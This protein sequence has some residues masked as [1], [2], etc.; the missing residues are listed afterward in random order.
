MTANRQEAVD[1]MVTVCEVLDEK[2]RAEVKV[3]GSPGQTYVAIRT[4][5]VSVLSAGGAAESHSFL[6]NLLQQVTTALAAL[7]VV[8]SQCAPQP[9]DTQPTPQA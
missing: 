3:Q 6:V 8:V 7:P 1:V 4:N 9:A 2:K 5:Q